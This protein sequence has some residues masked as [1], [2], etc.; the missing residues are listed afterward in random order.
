M[1]SAVER[2][3]PNLPQDILDGSPIG[4]A[5]LMLSGASEGAD[6]A[7]GR[8]A[9]AAG[10]TSAHILGPRNV[11][12]AECVSSQADA[13]YR[14]GDEL[15][16][17]EEISAALERASRLRLG[18]SSRMSG[19]LRDSR[20]NYLQVRRAEL[21]LCVAYRLPP[22]AEAPALDIGGGTGWAAQWYADRF[23][24]RGAEDPSLCQ[25]YLFDDG[26]PSWPGC[27]VDERTHR[28]WSK[29]CVEEGAWS[30]LAKGELPPRPATARVYAGIGST[31]LSTE[32]EQAIAALFTS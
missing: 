12:S 30:P 8:C 9:L 6:T 15:L 10:H 16:D 2:L 27:H 5:P 11:P 19:D 3:L 13:L 28:R 23:R 25:L 20:R 4:A 26:D 1:S 21:C 18:A 7:F 17:S 14:V 31:V 32:G 22:S 24:P 29:W